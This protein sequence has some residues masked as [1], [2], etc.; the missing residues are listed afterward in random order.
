MADAPIIPPLPPAGTIVTE[1]ALY[2]TQITL[3]RNTMAYGGQRNP[4][5]IWQSMQRDDGLAIPYY[6]EIEEKD[7]DAANA[8]DTL[9]DTVLNR[10]YWIEPADQS[11]QAQDVADFIQAQLDG[12]PDFHSVLA[13]LLDAPGYGFALGEMVFDVSM[14]QASLTDVL[15][16]PQ[17]LFL[18]NNRFYPQIGPLQF[19]TQPQASEG[20]LVPEEKFL[21]FSYRQ[22]ARNRMGRPLLRQVFWSS[23][24]K[25]NVQRLWLRYADK[26]PGTA[27]VR[28]QDSADQAG[29]QLAAEIA[30]ALVD[31]TAV[32]IP[33]NLEIIEELLKGARPISV[34]V[35]EHLYEAC[36]LDVVRRIL[37]ET[38]TSFGAEKGR[39]TQA[40]GTVHSDTLDDKSVQL[41]KALGGIFKRQLIRPLVLW[42]FG[43]NAPVPTLQF[44]VEEEKNLTERLGID[45]GLQGMGLTFTDAYLRETYAVPEPGAGD[46]VVAPNPNVAPGN[47]PSITPNF[48]ESHAGSATA[49]ANLAEFD[50]LVG[51]LQ[52]EAKDLMHQRVEEIT[53]ELKPPAGR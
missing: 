38:L 31:N 12:L 7:V 36:Q 1:N 14:G 51:Q 47:P 8:L 24:F 35:Y 19:L 20:D 2:N 53:H 23:W 37:G 46:I 49:E 28:Y 25:R 15:D 4:T 40:L 33:E 17:E 50:Q 16:C 27:A 52:D 5:S 9:R 3:W 21:V 42:N 6:R 30:Q 39:G 34:E 13:N 26:G 44:D 45:R 43:P 41:C 11:G 10:D 18:F 32:A 22:R 29:K 48:S